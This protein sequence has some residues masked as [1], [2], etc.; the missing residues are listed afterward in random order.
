MAQTHSEISSQNLRL[1]TLLKVRGGQTS[2]PILQPPPSHS[3]VK[4]VLN[5][6]FL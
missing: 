2:D 5:S 1:V 6:T 3:E 4:K